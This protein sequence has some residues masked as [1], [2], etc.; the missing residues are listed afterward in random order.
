MSFSSSFSLSAAS[1]LRTLRCNSARNV[2]FTNTSS[3][4]LPCLLPNCRSPMSPEH[5]LTSHPR[6]TDCI[7]MDALHIFL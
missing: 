2:D 6:I 5:L 4:S 3:D 7:R 1:A